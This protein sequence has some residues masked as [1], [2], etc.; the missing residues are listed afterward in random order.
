[1][2]QFSNLFEV[3]FISTLSMS[4]ALV[5]VK[6]AATMYSLLCFKVV[7]GTVFNQFI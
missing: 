1:M 4:M 2:Y 6:L 7:R 5:V 3:C